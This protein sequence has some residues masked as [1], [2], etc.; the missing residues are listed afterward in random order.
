LAPLGPT[1]LQERDAIIAAAQAGGTGDDVTDIWNGF[2]IR[3]M[4]Y[5][6]RITNPGSGGNDARVVEAFDL[7]NLFQAPAFTVNDSAGDGDGFPEPGE[8]LSLSIPLTNETGAAATGVTLQIVGGGSA[9]YGTIAH[10]QTVVRNVTYTVPADTACGSPLALTFEVDSSLG[11][12]EF[13]RTLN[14]GEPVVVLTEN[15]DGVTAPTLPSG[16]TGASVSGGPNFV[17]S[18]L[19]PESSPNA[20]FA[21]EPTTVGG[22]SDLTSPPIAIA[23]SAATLSFRHRYNTESGWDGAV[24]EIKIGAGG[25]QDILTAGG[26]FI[27]NGYVSILG[28]N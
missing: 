7:P 6:A 17:N 24:L 2:A 18:T 20:A 15:F 19:M 22:G 26:S 16:W 28:A 11:E 13:E 8:Q 5:S 27:E 10:G 25:F 3:G 23:T 1:F 9:N 4:G 12:T 14:I 21:Q